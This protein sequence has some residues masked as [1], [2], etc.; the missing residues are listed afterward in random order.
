MG[1]VSPARTPAPDDDAAR[2]RRRYPAS[3]LPRPVL[4]GIIAAMAAVGLGWLTWTA[5]IH[6]NPP[7]R[8]G[9]AAFTVLSDS[10]VAVTLTV[11]RPDPSIPVICTLI[12]QAE[13]FEHVGELPIKIGPTTARRVDAKVTMQTFRRATSVSLKQCTAQ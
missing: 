1:Q 6:S 9:V 12:A 7:V 2:I 13:N 11:E 8:G 4:V 5:T 3:R 10:K